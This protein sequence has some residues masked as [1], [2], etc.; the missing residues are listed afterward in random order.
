[1]TC[2]KLLLAGIATLTAN[3]LGA[4]LVFAHSHNRLIYPHT[5]LST[6]GGREYTVMLDP[7]HGGIDSGAVGHEAA[8]EKHVV[9]DIA[10]N[11]K[12]ILKGH[13]ND[14]L[15]TRSNDN[16]I[17]LND[18]VHIAHVH[19]ANLFMSIHADGFTSPSAYG[20]SVYALSTRGA[21]TALAN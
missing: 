8:P 16:F 15:L 20:A 13:G 12:T 1:M 3:S 14:A 10:N 18:R 9:L 7:R 5:P 6:G 21:S 11:I 17:P 4:P 2:R 19:R